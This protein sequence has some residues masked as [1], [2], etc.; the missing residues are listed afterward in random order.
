MKT[1]SHLLLATSL[2]LFLISCAPL[3]PVAPAERSNKVKITQQK[4][5]QQKKAQLPQTAPE[6]ASSHLPQ[7]PQ[8][9]QI[10][11]NVAVTGIDAWDN[12]L[13]PWLGTPYLYGGSSKAGT[14]CS[15]FVS[16]VYMEKEGIYLPRTARQ[17]FDLGTSI[18][19]SK[20]AVGD[21]V[22]FKERGRI[23][24]VGIF[25]GKESFI[26]ASTSL[27]V[28]VTSLNDSYWKPRY[29]GARRYL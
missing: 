6:Q 25:V 5:A 19:K 26:H 11:Q 20:L 7:T 21:L 9:P 14:D 24:H 18:K 17:E 27:G 12:V 22:F 28:T 1:T 4:S 2:L 23:S 3:Q 29:V 10:T 8:I 13:S 15:G 16:S